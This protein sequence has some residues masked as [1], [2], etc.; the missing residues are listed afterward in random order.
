LLGRRSRQTPTW[1]TE[2]TLGG[3][4]LIGF[5]LRTANIALLAT[6]VADAFLCRQ[7]KRGIVRALV[8]ILP[9]VAW[10]AH[11][12]QVERSS[13]YLRPAYAYQRAPYQHYNV[14]Y[15][16]N[17]K[18][19]EP[20]RPEAGKV[21]PV[22]VMKRFV[23]NALRMPATWGGATTVNEGYWYLAIVPFLPNETLAL[24]FATACAAVLGLVA[25]TGLGM[26]AWRGHRIPAL[27][28]GFG[29]L[30][31]C[32]TPW[33]SEFGRYLMPSASIV[34]LGLMFA[35]R[36]LTLTAEQRFVRHPFLCRGGAVVLLGFLMVVQVVS[37]RS[38]FAV[39]GQPPAQKA[40]APT[41]FYYDATWLRWEHA[42]AWIRQRAPVGTIVATT[43][44]H[45]CHL[46]T[47]LPS[48]MPPME[49]DT[50]NLVRLL[51]SVPVTFVVIDEMEFR[52]T[53]RRYVQP[54]LIAH[55]SEWRLVHEEGKTQVYQRIAG[56]APDRMAATP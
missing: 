6:W 2:A 32:L 49:R 15:A 24:A 48:V 16:E 56:I 45:M 23:R 40:A 30:P 4:A 54:A 5:L 51:D 52:D 19:I 21:T 11:V 34:V 7:W 43:A 38:M 36:E 42:L 18:L 29:T 10:Q 25:A 35:L 22:I 55:S 3:L 41:W 53:A 39:A 37:A 33:V 46:R 9:V 1:S 8:A 28:L 17:M 12:W 14:S 47:G 50:A 44:S 31:V 27:L 13:D 20:F 26:L